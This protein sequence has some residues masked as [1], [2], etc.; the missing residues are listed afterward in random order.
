MSTRTQVV[1]AWITIISVVMAGVGFFVVSG[2]VPPP[3]AYDTAQEISD[4]YRDN[5]T[6]LR[7]G[8]MLTFIAW[9]G[10]GTLTAGLSTQMQRI[11]QERP[12]LANLQMSSGTA[13]WACL[14]IPTMLL[15][16]ATYRPGRSPEITQTLHDL[17]WI[18]AFL[19]ITPFCVQAFAIAACVL[20]D[21]SDE[22]VFPRWL[23]YFSAWC[24]VLFIP[25]GLLAFFKTGPFAY[26][27]LFVFWVPFVVFGA[28]ILVLAWMVKRAALNEATQ[29]ASESRAAAT[30]RA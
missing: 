21:E 15:V 28:Y 2:Y 5:T 25:G 18:T 19:A 24:G 13:G 22:P 4:F 8:L 17:G 6:R 23:A 7:I 30:A 14:L 3:K 12:I 16:A 10:W 9:A 20:K 11:E 1:A 29:S 27:G 26:H